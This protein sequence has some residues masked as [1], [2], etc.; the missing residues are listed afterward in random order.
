M[1]KSGEIET[2]REEL[3]ECMKKNSQGINSDVVKKSEEL[4]K[5]LNDYYKSKNNY[6]TVK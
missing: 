2:K 1:D 5:C 4:D 6:K 3:I